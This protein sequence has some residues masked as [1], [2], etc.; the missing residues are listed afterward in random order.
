MPV[1]VTVWGVDQFAWSNVSV[2][3]STVASPVSLDATLNVSVLPASMSA[4]GGLLR[5]TVNVAVD[6]DSATATEVLE[7][8]TFQQVLV[9]DVG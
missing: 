3:T 6:P 1:T 7:M 9:I 2:E 5:T 8:S 4:S